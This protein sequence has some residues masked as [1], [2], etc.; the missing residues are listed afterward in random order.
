[1]S[2]LLD[3]LNEEKQIT[4]NIK[5]FQGSVAMMQILLLIR[6]SNL[7]GLIRLMEGC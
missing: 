2:A 5:Y 7:D 6:F 1:M 3:D 4:V